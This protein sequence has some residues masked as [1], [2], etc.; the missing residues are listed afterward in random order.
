MQDV[1]KK[2]GAPSVA[3]IVLLRLRESHPIV[4]LLI[5]YHHKSKYKSFLDSWLKFSTEEDPYLHTIFSTSRVKSGR[6][7][8]SNPNLQQVKLD[9]RDVFIA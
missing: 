6:F 4:E 8:S 5:D 3:S 2:T 7:S 1:S 9:W